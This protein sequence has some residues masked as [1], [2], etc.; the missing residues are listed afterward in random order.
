MKNLIGQ[1][2]MSL[3]KTNIIQLLKAFS[4]NEVKEFDKFVHSPFLNNRAEV[5]AFFDKIKKYYPCFDQTD[6]T[7]KK[8]YD[9]LYPY[10][11]YRDDVIRRLC[12]NLFKL[13]E[14]YLSY[15]S[16]RNEKFDQ[17]KNLL[18]QYQRRSE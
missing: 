11:G 13:A 10:S 8:V 12:S 1:T 5:A 4:K 9:S 6:F 14:D 7:K 16:F 15:N 18:E 17:H 3:N 2:N